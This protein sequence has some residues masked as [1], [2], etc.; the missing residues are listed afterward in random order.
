MTKVHSLLIGD[1]MFFK[2]AVQ[3]EAFI[4]KGSLCLSSFKIYFF[5]DWFDNKWMQ[6]K[7]L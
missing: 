3:L 5:V 6:L 7:L 4:T 2:T 1:F